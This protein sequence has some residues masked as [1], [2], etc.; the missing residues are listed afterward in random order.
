MIM[1]NCIL[2]INY[3]IIITKNK[4]GNKKQLKK[5]EWLNLDGCK[6]C[7]KMQENNKNNN[8]EKNYRMPKIKIWNNVNT[9]KF[10]KR[11]ISYIKFLKILIL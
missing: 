11:L 6:I 4:R 9:K 3:G 10:D 8:Y 1:Y 2:Q 5:K 7:I